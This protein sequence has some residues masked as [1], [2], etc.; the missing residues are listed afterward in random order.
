MIKCRLTEVCKRT[1]GQGESDRPVRDTPLVDLFEAL[2]SGAAMGETDERSRRDVDK[3]VT[4]A[5]SRS[6]DDSV[7]DARE[8]LDTGVLDG[9]DERRASS[10][11]S[12]A[13]QSRVSVRDDH[14]DDESRANVEQADSVQDSLGGLGD[15]LG[16]VGSLGGGQD[17]SLGTRV[18]VSGVDESSEEGGES[19]GSAVD[20]EVVGGVLGECTGVL[21]VSETDSV[22]RGG[23]S[24]VDNQTEN[25]KAGR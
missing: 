2:G 25:E 11:S 10:V 3:R 6:E 13:E 8:D 9:D 5:P 14:A 7:D 20:D 21:P 1:H 17:D 18:R 24:E 16:R 22:A 15:L 4:R 23:S 19:A 12:A